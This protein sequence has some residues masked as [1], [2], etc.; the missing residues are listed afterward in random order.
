MN[1][2]TIDRSEQGYTVLRDGQAIAT[3]QRADEAIEAMRQFRDRPQQAHRAN[4]PPMI[5]LMRARWQK[6]ATP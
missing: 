2:F 3:F 1:H 5:Q 4:T 6:P